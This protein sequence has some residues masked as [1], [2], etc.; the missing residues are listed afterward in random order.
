M[1]QKK[2]TDLTLRTDFDVT[3]ILP[4]DDAAQTWRV[5]GQQMLDFMR[6]QLRPPPSGSVVMWA[7]SSAPTG[8]LLC[9]GATISRTTYAALFAIVGTT[10][11]AGD[12]S[13]TFKLPDTQGVFVRGSGSQTISGITHT[14]TRGTTEGDQ[15]QGHFHGSVRGTAITAGGAGAAA[16]SAGSG[17]VGTDMVSAPS[18]DGTNGTPRTG[19]Q[20]R[21]ANI[22]MNYIIKI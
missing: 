21:P 20:T 5:T 18:T 9:D 12:G 16:L 17:F 11:G 13:T 8:W 3:C 10:Y 19:A 6:A 22:T 14:G 7:G 15:M 2:I 4:A 1:A